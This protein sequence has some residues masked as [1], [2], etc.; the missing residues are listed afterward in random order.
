MAWVASLLLLLLLGGGIAAMAVYRRSIRQDDSLVRELPPEMLIALGRA[1][2]AA[3][4]G[5]GNGDRARE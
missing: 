2:E 5:G 1:N 4:D 3:R